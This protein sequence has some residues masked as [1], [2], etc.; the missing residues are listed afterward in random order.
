MALAALL[1][2]RAAPAKEVGE[3]KFAWASS[4]GQLREVPARRLGWDATGRR[5]LA[6]QTSSTQYCSTA[7]LTRE[8]CTD[9]H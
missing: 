6:R 9:V 7:V 3:G 2:R 4:A 5:L 1:E 8:Y